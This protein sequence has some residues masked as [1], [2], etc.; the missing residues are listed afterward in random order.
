M[1]TV[2]N[3]PFLADFIQV[4][5]NMPEDER[6]QLEQF[7]GE[8]YDI[9]G[10][11]IGNYTAPGPKWVIK[12]GDDQ[13]AFNLG[14][15]RPIVVG[16]FVPQRPGVWRD[17]LLTTPDAWEHWFAV[18]RICRRVMDA[19]LISGQAHRLECIVPVSRLEKRPEL[20]KWYKVLG[21]NKEGLHHGYCAD[22]ADAI[23]F[24]RVR[25]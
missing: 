5:A 17:F 12:V 3:N 23:S 2:F 11:A 21:Y 16:G 20:E 19:M 8:K 24:A 15:A 4:A 13:E 7:T 22:G 25:H 10:V 1:I 9:D 6:K 18:T 14:L